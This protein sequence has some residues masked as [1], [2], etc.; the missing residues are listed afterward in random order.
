M[1]RAECAE[2]L[3][4]V[5]GEDELELDPA[6]LEPTPA[7]QILARVLRN[8]KQVWLAREEWQRALG[9]AE[10]ILLLAPDTPV[11][12][13]DRGLL[14][15]RLECFAAAEADLRRFLLLAPDDPT[16]DAVR[17]QVEELSRTSPRL[18]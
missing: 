18:H 10:R 7:R 8:L 11:E 4:A 5:S 13:R 17:A 12:L 1:T 16:A 2:R 6:L 15:A 14:Y 9:C 3:R